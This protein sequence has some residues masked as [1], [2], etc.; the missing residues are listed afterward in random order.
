MITDHAYDAGWPR[1]DGQGCLYLVPMFTFGQPDEGDRA[2]CGQPLSE[3]ANSE[4]AEDNRAPGD[5]HEPKPYTGELDW[6]GD[7]AL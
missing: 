7:T 6:S 3:H 5:M 4:Y 2:E 1:D